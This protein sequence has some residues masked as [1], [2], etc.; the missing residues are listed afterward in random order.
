[1][2]EP[3]WKYFSSQLGSG[4]APWWV[5]WSRWEDFLTI[6]LQNTASQPD[7]SRKRAALLLL[8]GRCSAPPQTFWEQA[9]LFV[10]PL[11]KC[12]SILCPNLVLVA[13]SFRKVCNLI[14]ELP[15][16]A[17]LRRMET[18]RKTKS[19]NQ[20]ISVETVV[21][22]FQPNALKLTHENCLLT[23][24]LRSGTVR[25][26]SGSQADVWFVWR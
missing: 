9:V 6:T 20:H 3:A 7:Q 18:F 1:M 19:M 17:P 16:S 2:V 8:L 15:W 24:R 26:T 25:V 13:V 11:S 21:Y 10:L 22:T 12:T 5:S 4:Q 23:R 14:P